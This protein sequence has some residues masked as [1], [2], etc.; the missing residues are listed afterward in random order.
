MTSRSTPTGPRG[1]RTLAAGLLALTACDAAPRAPSAS[2]GLGRTPS[3]AALAAID[4]DVDP[5]GH[6][7][8]AG[9]GTAAAGASVF[10]ARC[11][12]CHGARG[13]GVSPVPPLVG[14]TPDA[15]YDF[16]RAERAPRTIGNYWPYATTIFDYVRRAMPLD[17]PGS[18]TA[19]ETYAVVAWLLHENGIIRAETVI[20]ATTLPAVVMPARHIFV[21]DDRR[22]G[23]GFR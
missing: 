9:S 4:I 2:F 3:A 7:L 18:L 12:S 6:G 11:A 23:R 14:R 17:A 19:A 13:Q 8:P 22:A 16:A 20:D 15:G 1:L 5:S 10:A 21:P